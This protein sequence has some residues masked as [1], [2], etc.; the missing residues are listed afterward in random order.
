MHTVCGTVLRTS[1][2]DSDGQTGTAGNFPLTHEN[3]DLLP[4]Q[5]KGEMMKG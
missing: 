2:T 1:S 5:V 4:I 3:N